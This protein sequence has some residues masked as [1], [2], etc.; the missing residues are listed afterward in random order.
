M[1]C[2]ISASTPPCRAEEKDWSKMHRSRG[3]NCTGQEVKTALVKRSIL[4]RSRGQYCTGQEVKTAPV[5][6]YGHT[7]RHTRL[8][9][10]V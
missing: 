5:K 2:W 3:Q 4:H 8:T 1:G 7:C 10:G 6:R 9:V